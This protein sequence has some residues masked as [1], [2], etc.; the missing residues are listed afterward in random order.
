MIPKYQNNEIESPR[1]SHFRPVHEFILPHVA[2]ESIVSIM[3]KLLFPS[4]VF[5]NKF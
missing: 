3:V 1:I 2:F 4:V 5:V